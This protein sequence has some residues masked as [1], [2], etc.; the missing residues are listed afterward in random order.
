M[1]CH[2][3][4]DGRLDGSENPHIRRLTTFFADDVL[5]LL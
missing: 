5:I 1:Y 3:H 4:S 2:S